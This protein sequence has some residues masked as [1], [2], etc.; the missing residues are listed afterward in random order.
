M[1]QKVVITEVN[2]RRKKLRKVD[3]SKR[4]NI[5]AISFPERQNGKNL[6]GEG[7]F[8]TIA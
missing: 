2:Y 4:S 1:S 3:L 5:Q 7:T 8:K 6:K